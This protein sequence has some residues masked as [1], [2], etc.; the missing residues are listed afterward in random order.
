MNLQ[1]GEQASWNGKE[2]LAEPLK[3]FMKEKMKIIQNFKRSKVKI[4]K[5]LKNKN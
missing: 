2:L 3:E 4:T 1:A 5:C